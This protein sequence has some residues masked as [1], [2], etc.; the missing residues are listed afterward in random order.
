MPVPQRGQSTVEYAILTVGVIIPLTFGIIYLA[1]ML[2]VWH[3]VTDLTRDGARYAA[4]HC[5]QA[6]AD[7]VITY[8]RT[9]VPL[10]IDRDQFTNGTADIQVNYFSRDP[11]S[12]TLADFTCDTECSASCVPDAVTV[13]VV[14]YQFR[15]F[16]GY[17]GIPPVQMPDFRTSV[18]I[19]SAGCDPEQGFCQP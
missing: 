6:S 4:T 11:A 2:W 16:V 18:A 19:E 5:W 10:M 12:G 13:R 1:Q 17:L 7:N 14:N 9:N 8:M 15:N 3:S